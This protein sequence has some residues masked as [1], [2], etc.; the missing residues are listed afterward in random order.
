L[1]VAVLEEVQEQRLKVQVPMAVCQLLFLI[2]QQVVVVEDHKHQV[3][4]H[5]TIMVTLVVQVVVVA[6]Q[7]VAVEQVTHLLL[8]LLKVIMVQQ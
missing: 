4:P 2:H 5:L 3:H 1:V 6:I 7:V 8:V